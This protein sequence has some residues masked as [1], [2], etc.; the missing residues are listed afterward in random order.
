MKQAAISIVIKNLLKEVLD[1]EPAYVLTIGV[2]IQ[3]DDA[4]ATREVAM[5]LEEACW[6]VYVIV[7]GFGVDTIATLVLVIIVVTEGIT[8][9]LEL[10]IVTN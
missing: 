1:A 9:W 5:P 10:V 2:V 4:A 7:V 3:V 6:V 8:V